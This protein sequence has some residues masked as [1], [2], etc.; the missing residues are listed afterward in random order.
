MIKTILFDFG[1][2]F[3]NLDKAA[4]LRELQQLG[5]NDFSEE[6]L[7]WNTSYETGLL[8]SEG[9]ISNYQKSFPN[10]SKEALLN[11]WNAILLD[12][13]KHRLDFLQELANEIKYQCI[14]LS[15]TN[16]IHIDWVMENIPHFDAFK[17]CFTAFYLSHEIQLRKPNKD[18]YE[19]ILK[20]HNLKPEEVFFIDDTK[21]NTDAAK[22]LGIH[23]WNID[24]AKEDI[25]QLLQRKEFQE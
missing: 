3:L 13:P 25:T 15:N 12:F 17:A 21:E 23:V 19:F 18:V 8:D 10:V 7:Q 22:S 1:D 24:P 6:M 14:L 11:A 16:E 5:V 20:N 2:V 9:F 4:T